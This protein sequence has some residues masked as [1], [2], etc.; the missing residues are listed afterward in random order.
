MAA[1]RDAGGDATAVAGNVSEYEECER[2]V[3]TARDAYGPIDVLVNN[4][5]LTYFI[6]VAEFPVNRWLRSTAV[7]FHRPFFMSQLCLQDMI[8][9]RSGAII[10]ISSG[11][12]IGPGRGPYPGPA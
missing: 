5:A 2:I 4:A 7:N 9:R 1:I 8:G 11:A 6:P 12:A 3:Q 10:N